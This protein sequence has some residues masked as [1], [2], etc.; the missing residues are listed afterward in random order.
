MLGHGPSKTVDQTP[1]GKERAGALVVWAYCLVIPRGVGLV[2]EYVYHQLAFHS[3]GRT[4][5][6]GGSPSGFGP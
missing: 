1:P 6:R 5:S 2:N 3:S 4:V